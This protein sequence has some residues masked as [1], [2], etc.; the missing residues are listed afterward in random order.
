MAR[1]NRNTL[2]KLAGSRLKEARILLDNKQWT[3]AYYMTGLAVECAL[4]SSLAGSVKKHDFP[5]KKFVNEMYVHNL[6]KLFKLNG[7]LWADLQADIGT[8]PKLRV[9]WSTVKDWDD[10][11]RYDVVKKLEAKALFEATTQAGSGV[12]G[13]IQKKW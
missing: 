10:S 13:W 11:K 3:G 2:R 1:L 8:D 4:K 7:A 5:D 9:N 6:E 12:M